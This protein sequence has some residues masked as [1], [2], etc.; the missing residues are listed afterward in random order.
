M[1]RQTCRLNWGMACWKTEFHTQVY[2]CN[3]SERKTRQNVS[4]P[5]SGTGHH[6]TKDMEKSMFLTTTFAFK[7][8]GHLRRRPEKVWKKDDLPL[9]EES[10]VREHLNRLDIQKSM[11]PDRMH[12]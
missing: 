11:G 9:V 7:N 8:L 5:L 1:Q 3:S 2:R 12:V 4:S 10:Q 6:V